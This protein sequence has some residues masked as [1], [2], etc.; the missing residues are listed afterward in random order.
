[1][2]SGGDDGSVKLWNAQ[3]DPIKSIDAQQGSVRSISWSG[4]GQ[5]LASGGDDG[6]VKLLPTEDLDALLVKGCRWLNSYLIGTPQALQKLT[7]C[8]TP[9]LL[10]AAAPN[11]VEDSEGLAS[12]GDVAGAVAGFR[13][14]QE[15][16]PSLTFDP[17]ARANELAEAAKSGSGDR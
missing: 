3:G 17:V 2:A 4:D 14:A 8:Q 5:T 6:S 11:L 12:H 10:R 9:D 15:W 16:N 13:M 7:V 1:L